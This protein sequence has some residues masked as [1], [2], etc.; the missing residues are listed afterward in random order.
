MNAITVTR[1]YGAGGYEAAARLADA[2][3]DLLLRLHQRAVNRQGA[4]AFIR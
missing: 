3:G 2:L 4:L 1:E